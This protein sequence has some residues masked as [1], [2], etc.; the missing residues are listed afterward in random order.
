MVIQEYCFWAM[1][2]GTHGS[3]SESL[4]GPPRTSGGLC[5]KASSAQPEYTSAGPSVRNQDAPNPLYPGAGCSQF[6]SFSDL[7]KED[8]LVAAAQPPFVNP[9]NSSQFIPSSIPQFLRTRPILD[10]NHGNATTRTPTY[11]GF[12]PGSDRERWRSRLTCF[13]HAICRQ[14]CCGG[15]LV[16]RHSFSTTISKQYF[17]A[18]WGRA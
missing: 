18:D 5:L 4:Q 9:C 16:H 1:S 13:G 3:A 10:W 17:F 7:L 8:S 14:L 11:R 12:G 15:H 2:V 6:F